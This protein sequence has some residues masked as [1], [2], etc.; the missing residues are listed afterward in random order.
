MRQQAPSL[1]AVE[2]TAPASVLERRL[3]DRGRE[4][5]AEVARRLERRFSVPVSLT[6]AN[7]GTLGATVDA[8]HAWWSGLAGDLGD[9]GS[10]LAFCHRQREAE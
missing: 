7:T 1:H 10:G 4:D 9:L 8:L 5:A 6:L 3:A 2:V